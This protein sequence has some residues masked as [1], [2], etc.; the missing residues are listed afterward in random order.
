M[1]GGDK[2]NRRRRRLAGWGGDKA[3]GGR[4]YPMLKGSGEIRL[5][6]KRGKCH[7]DY[8]GC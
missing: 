2:S 6:D 5:G 7:L 8:R 3:E 1:T 4:G